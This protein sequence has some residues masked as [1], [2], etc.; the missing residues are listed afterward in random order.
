MSIVRFSKGENFY[1]VEQQGSLQEK[2]VTSMD[3]IEPHNFRL[4]LEVSE[5]TG[6]LLLSFQVFNYGTVVDMTSLLVLICFL[7]P[8][9]SPISAFFQLLYFLL[10]FSVSGNG[11]HRLRHLNP[12]SPVC[13][14][15]CEG[16][17]GVALWDQVC[18]YV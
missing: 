6:F 4:E 1:I 8:P 7:S 3:E 10:P 2:R 12:S 11:P 5:F 18:H 16:L 17:G 14:G 15:F 13:E 9:P